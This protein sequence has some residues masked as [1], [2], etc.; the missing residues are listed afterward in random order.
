MLFYEQEATFVLADQDRLETSG[1]V[2]GNLERE[3]AE[4]ALHGF[5]ARA[6]P[7]VAAVIGDSSVR[8]MPEMVGHFG[9]KCS[10]EQNFGELFEQPVFSG[11]VF[12]RTAALKELVDEFGVEFLGHPVPLLSLLQDGIYTKISELPI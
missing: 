11:D 2:S 10:L 6:V 4:L 1:S 8:L 7:G 3:L 12:G 9:L 5:L